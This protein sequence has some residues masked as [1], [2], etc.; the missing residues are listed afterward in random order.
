MSYEETKNF[1][2][3]LGGDFEGIGAQINISALGILVEGTLP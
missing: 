1:D 2:E 3:A